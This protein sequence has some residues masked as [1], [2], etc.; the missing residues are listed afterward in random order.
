MSLLSDE[1]NMPYRAGYDRTLNM[2]SMQVSATRR[3]MEI[4]LDL[5][6]PASVTG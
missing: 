1:E 4:N 2:V 5:A 6:K 3:K